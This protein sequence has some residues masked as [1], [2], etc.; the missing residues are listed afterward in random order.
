MDRVSGLGLA[1]AAFAAFAL[2]VGVAAGAQVVQ[3][4][5]PTP[6]A[7]TGG[8]VASVPAS[9][10]EMPEV[11]AATEEGDMLPAG[12]SDVGPAPLPLTS[13]QPTAPLYTRIPAPKIDGPRR[14][15]IQ[16]G[17][18]Q[19]QQAPPEL[20]RLLT[21]TGSSF[22]GLDEVG[23]NLDIAE[24]IKAILEPKGYVVDVLPTTIPPGYVADAFVALHA[25]SDGVGENSGFKMA[26]SARR[27]PFEADL[28]DT[29]KSAYGDATGL[30]YDPLRVSRAMT[31]YYAMSW[32]RNKWSTAPHTPSVILEM[33][34][35]SNYADRVLMTQRASVVADAIATGL[36][37]FLVAYPRDQLFGQDLLVPAAPVFR[38]RPTPLPS[39]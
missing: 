17:H 23:I 38:L 8:I 7:P 31:N 25:D 4:G 11:W 20:W 5:L 19:T 14:V 27:T 28:M 24:R 13:A 33:G 34:Y 10:A 3:G 29:I 37:R 35:I 1:V 36:V 26:F 6:F 30:D 32:Q 16:A 21:S 18:W 2:V 39:P 12:P 9:L 22:G 15:G